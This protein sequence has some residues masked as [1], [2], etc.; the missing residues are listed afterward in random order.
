MR[1]ARRTILAS[2]LASIAA[3]F[4]LRLARADTP[5]TLK[6]HH[7]VSSVS[8]GHDKFL[9]PWARKVEQESGGRLRIDI[10]PSMQLGGT[11]AQL[12]DQARDG[13][14]D[15]AWVVPSLT[16]GR[17]PKIEMFELPFVPARRAL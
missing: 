8:S 5:I 12:F 11:P 7:F 9:V 10:F 3:P 15:L 16:P 13:I 4:I 2:T 14:V 6:L 1:V 17:F